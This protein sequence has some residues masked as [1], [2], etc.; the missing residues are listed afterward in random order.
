MSLF[1][2][3]KRRNVIRVGLAYLIVAWLVMQVADV[4]LNNVVA[5]SWVFWVILLILAIGLVIVL[6]FSWVFELT[7][8]GLK[9]ETVYY[10]IF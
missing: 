9:R 5:P 2:E 10:Q 7:P 8:E 1:V 6:V 4:V 3:L